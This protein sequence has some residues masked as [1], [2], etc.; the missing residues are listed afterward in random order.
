MKHKASTVKDG[1]STTNGVQQLTGWLH[2]DTSK[3]NWFLN[4]PL[5]GGGV[6]YTYQCLYGCEY[7]INNLT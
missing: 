4:S 7:S 6:Q 3:Q 5:E 1:M 2:L